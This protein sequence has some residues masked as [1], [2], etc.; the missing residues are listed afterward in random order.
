MDNRHMKRCSTLLSIREMQIKTT[1]WYYL[2][3]VK[4]DIIK[5]LPVDGNGNYSHYR[6]NIKFPPKTISR[7]TIWSSNHKRWYRDC[8]LNHSVLEWF[9]TQQHITC[10][11]I[12]CSPPPL[13]NSASFCIII[14]FNW[15]TIALQCCTVFCHAAT[16]ISHKCID[17]LCMP[18]CFSCVQL[19]V[20][21]CTVAHRAS[22]CM[23]LSKQEVGCRALLQG[24]FPTQGL[25][26]HLLHFLR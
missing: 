19:C 26:P 9:I 24:I 23:G 5:S 14:I 18:S 10:N 3:P 1:M 7:T 12:L 17:N 4:M 11:I 2:K 22:L 8:G 21:L 13:H 20:T 25:K 15:R 16:W 6:N